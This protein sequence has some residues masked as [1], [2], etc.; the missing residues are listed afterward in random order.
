MGHSSVISQI[1]MDRLQGGSRYLT[2]ITAK[3]TTMAIQM[4]YIDAPMSIASTANIVR[5]K[6]SMKSLKFVERAKTR[7]VNWPV[8]NIVV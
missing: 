5:G 3:G 7:T 1:Q 6:M 8:R 2:S 4:V